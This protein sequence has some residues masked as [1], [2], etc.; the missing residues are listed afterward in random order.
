MQNHGPENPS[1]PD[2]GKIPNLTPSG[3]QKDSSGE[4]ANPSTGDPTKQ[5][6][7]KNNGNTGGIAKA[8][9]K[10]CFKIHKIVYIIQKCKIFFQKF[11]IILNVK[12]I[13]A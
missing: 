12:P 6:S 2:N 3:P 11:N 5:D 7:S 10:V 1:E 9:K 4:S 13:Q 8:G